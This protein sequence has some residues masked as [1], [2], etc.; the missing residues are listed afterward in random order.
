MKIPECN[1]LSIDHYYAKVNGIL[2]FYNFFSKAPQF[3]IQTHFFSGQTKLVN[4]LIPKISHA[5]IPFLKTGKVALTK[6]GQIKDVKS[7]K[8]KRLF[9]KQKER[10][11]NS[12]LDPLSYLYFRKDH[13]DI[14]VEPKYCKTTPKRNFLL[15]KMIVC[16][17]HLK[18]KY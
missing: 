16:E 8:K 15:I 11:A 7:I 18:A 13:I 17:N 3:Q 9:I 10:V 1:E 14:N 2:S 12:L 5:W 6:I 4:T